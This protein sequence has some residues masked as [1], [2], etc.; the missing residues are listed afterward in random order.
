MAVIGSHDLDELEAV[1][2]VNTLRIKGEDFV[3]VGKAIFESSEEAVEARLDEMSSF[4]HAHEGGLTIYE[5]KGG[6][7]EELQF[8]LTEAPPLDCVAIHDFI[9]FAHGSKVEI[10]RF[11]D[12]EEVETADNLG[13][14]KLDSCSFAF[15]A[16][17]LAV[18]RGPEGDR[19]VVGDAMR[20]ILVLDVDKKDGSI[21]RN[22]RDM[23]SHAVRALA[24]VRD[25]GPG[26]IVTD[27][28][29]ALPCWLYT[30]ST[31]SDSTGP[32]KRAHVPAQGRD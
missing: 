24:A 13:F 1:T 31:I 3:A 20:S 32:R 16:H 19:L 26:A 7:F 4:I 14:T 21:T 23:S 6:K 25:D 9:A 17:F 18:S 29:E 30:I 22:Q 27:V 12:D 28:S 10:W 11:T 2:S 8:M 5:H 15:E